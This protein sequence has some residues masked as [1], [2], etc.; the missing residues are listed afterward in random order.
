MRGISASTAGA[1]RNA[2]AMYKSSGGGNAA[3]KSYT[4][5]ANRALSSGQ[6]SMSAHKAGM[7][8]AGLS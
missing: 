6:S 5:G 8:S 7:T 2:T 1:M 3:Q 4:S